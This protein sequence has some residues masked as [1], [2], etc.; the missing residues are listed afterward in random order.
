MRKKHKFPIKRIE[1][2][3]EQL[4]AILKRVES[5]D[6]EQRDKELLLAVMKMYIELKK[7]QDSGDEEALENI[8]QYIDES[9]KD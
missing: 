2:T 9:I 6:I 8:L 3:Q 7:A 5:V 1:E 4:E